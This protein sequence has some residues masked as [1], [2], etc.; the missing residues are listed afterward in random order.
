MAAALQV[1]L[2]SVRYDHTAL[3][4]PDFVLTDTSVLT[5]IEVWGLD[6][7]EHLRRKAIKIAEYDREGTN[8]IGWRPSEPLLAIGNAL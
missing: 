8:L 1:F 6:S 5:V 2:K 4:L 3:V 7:E